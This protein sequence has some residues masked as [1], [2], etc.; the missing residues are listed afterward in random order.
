MNVMIDIETLGT[1]PGCVVVSIGAVKFDFNTGITSEF[2]ASVDIDDCQLHGLEID[3]ETMKWWMEQP[4]AVQDQLHGGETLVGALNNLSQF[5]ESQDKIWANSPSFDCSILEAAYE[6]VGQSVPWEYYNQ[7]D[8][9]TVKHLVT[10]AEVDV[11]GPKHNAQAD[12]RK[13]AQK[14]ITTLNEN[15]FIEI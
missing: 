14:L 3:S 13:Q 12:A 7:R 10:M 1:S 9:R 11:D 5:I 2:Y 6:A 4:D 15:P 8:Y